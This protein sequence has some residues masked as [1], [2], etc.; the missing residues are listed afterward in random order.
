MTKAVPVVR[1][2]CIVTFAGVSAPERVVP[3]EEIYEGLHKRGLW[4]FVS[5]RADH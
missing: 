2:G 3:A 1:P 4:Y 5:G